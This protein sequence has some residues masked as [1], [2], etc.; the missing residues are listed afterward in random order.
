MN[1]MQDIKQATLDAIKGAKYH[2]IM[3]KQF[4]TKNEGK[5]IK[6]S[7]SNLRDEYNSYIQYVNQGKLYEPEKEKDKAGKWEK[8]S[9]CPCTE[10]MAEIIGMCP[11]RTGHILKICKEFCKNPFSLGWLLAHGF[12]FH[13]DLGEKYPGEWAEIVKDVIDIEDFAKNTGLVRLSKFTGQDLVIIYTR[14]LQGVIW[15]I[16]DIHG[17]RIHGDYSWNMTLFR[18]KMGEYIDNDPRIRNS[19]I[20]E[21]KEEID[22]RRVK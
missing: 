2:N 12:W 13:A 15:K 20:V 9:G 19:A 6:F 1:I 5:T 14:I 11:E 21:E 4:N 16:T 18:K 7:E 3:V 10:E 17:N 22:P 8:Y